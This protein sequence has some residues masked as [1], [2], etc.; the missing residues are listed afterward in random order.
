MTER[1]CYLFSCPRFGTCERHRGGACSTR[2]ADYSST[3]GPADE[4][5][6]GECTPEQGF[7]FYLPDSWTRRKLFRERMGLEN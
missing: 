6:P 4:I 1:V 5:L 2:A 7:P 3:L